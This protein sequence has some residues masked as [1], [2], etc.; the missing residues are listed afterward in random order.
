[1]KKI[2]DDIYILKKTYGTRYFE[3]Y[4]AARQ[5]SQGNQN[6]C[7]ATQLEAIMTVPYNKLSRSHARWFGD[8]D[9]IGE[10]LEIVNDDDDLEY[11]ISQNID[12]ERSCSATVSRMMRSISKQ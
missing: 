6:V 9:T 11:N 10:D 5:R 4:S 8:D 3:V 1:M 7:T 12:Y 2:Q